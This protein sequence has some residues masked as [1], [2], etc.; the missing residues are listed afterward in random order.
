MSKQQHTLCFHPASIFLFFITIFMAGSVWAKT[1][2]DALFQSMKVRQP[3]LEEYMKAPAACL[4]ERLDGLL[5]INYNCPDKAKRLAEAEN[6]DRKALY[7]LM[8]ADLGISAEEVGKKRAQQNQDQYLPGVLREVRLSATETTW[9]EGFPPDP[10]KTAISRVLTLRYASIHKLP[11]ASSAVVRDNIQQ[12]EAFGVV[13]KD[14]GNAGD[15]WYKVTEDYVPKVKPSGWSPKALGWIAEKDAIPWRQ[16]LVM[17]FTNAYQ[18]DPSFFFNEPA[19]LLKLIE[20]AP[21]QRERQLQNIRSQFESG[22]SKT[23]GPIAMEPGV[24]LGQER[25]IMYPVLDFYSRESGETLRVDGRFARLLKVA[26]RTRA[27]EQGRGSPDVIPIDILFVMDTTNSMKPYI[28]MVLEAT[29]KFAGMSDD[30]E[31]RFGFIGYQDKH[32]DFD[33]RIKEFT[34]KTQPAHDFVRT[35]GGVKARSVSVKGD[36]IPESVFEG[37]NA[38]IEGAQWREDAV[39]IIFLVGD[40]PG[41]EEA[42]NV[43]RLRD[44][45]FTRNISIFAFHIQNSKVSKRYDK[46]SKKQYRKLSSTFEGSYGNSRETAHFL[47]IDASSVDFGKLVTDRFQEAR[48]SFK[49][50]SDAARSGKTELPKA[51]SGSLSELIFQQAMLLMPDDSLPDEEIR[52]WVCDKVLINPGRE[53]LAPMILL[54]EAELDELEQR[55][56][57]LKEIGEEALRGEGGT[58]LDFFDLVSMNTRF[59]M[60]DPTAVNFRDTFAVPLGIDKLPYES[61]IMATTREEFHNPDRVQGFVRAMSNKLRHYEDLRRQRGDTNIW[62]KLSTGAGERD[63]VV[64]V[65][66]NQLP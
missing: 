2:Y 1:D 47:P 52:G 55:V 32:P 44:K 65:E 37:L 21:K 58:T 49:V 60:V 6:R 36:D 4:G 61:D 27:G 15:I 66:L 35:L 57:E 9:W 28:K 11:D 64:G 14:V 22:K 42:F 43:S 20:I 46:Q 25:I 5:E 56:R 3:Q 62:K 39:K 40:A 13:G 24:G 63:R 29:E 38:A 59:T 19:P 23:D 51:D 26:A 45:A 12:Y 48:K 10:R 31:L 54:N 30:S 7:E 18:R 53:A 34:D 33:Y 16:A 41:R 17:R 8:S 50:I